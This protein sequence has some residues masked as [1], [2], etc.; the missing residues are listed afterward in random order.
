MF[1]FIQA[2]GMKFT[3]LRVASQKSRAWV[4]VMV[5]AGSAT[6]T[7]CVVYEPV[8]AP[9]A[10]STFDRAW[11]ASLAA[12]QDEGVRITSEDRTNG[13]IRGNEGSKR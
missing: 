8:A 9:P 7:G 3:A 12:A 11:S 1:F 13:V 2:Q 10:P 6:L 5:V 4:A